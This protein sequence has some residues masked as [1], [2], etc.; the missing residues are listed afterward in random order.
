MSSATIGSNNNFEYVISKCSSS[1]SIN[2]TFASLLTFTQ[3]TNYGGGYIV[4]KNGA[5]TGPLVIPE[6]YNG[7]DVVAIADSA[8]AGC[9]ITS[10]DIPSVLYIGASAFS[11]CNQLTGTLNININGSITDMG[12][13]GNKA[14]ENCTNITSLQITGNFESIGTGAFYA[15]ENLTEVT[16]GHPRSIGAEAFSWCSGLTSITIPYSVSS[17]GDSA[18]LGCNNLLNIAFGNNNDDSQ[19]R[20]IGNGAFMECSSLQSIYIPSNVQSI[21][22]QAFYGCRNAKTVLIASQTVID[23]LQDSSCSGCLLLFGIFYGGQPSG[24]VRIKA[25]LTPTAYLAS[26]T[27]VYQGLF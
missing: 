16:M 20:D 4:A 2:V 17:I 21:G 27:T 25:G 6:T 12:Q 23:M 18:F 14:F 10:V 26:L 13:I 15:C 7:S 1:H 24:V 22:Q 11:G 9:A 19:L 8:F 3:T 5:P